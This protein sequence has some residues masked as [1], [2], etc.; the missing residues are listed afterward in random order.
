MT[1]LNQDIKL[2][3]EERLSAM[4]KLFKTDIAGKIERDLDRLN[5]Y[6]NVLERDLFS[7]M[8]SIKENLGNMCSR[9]T[10]LFISYYEE[11]RDKIL[12]LN[13][14]YVYAWMQ[15]TRMS[16]GLLFDSLDFSEKNKISTC[17]KN[18]VLSCKKFKS[19]VFDTGEDFSLLENLQY[20]PTEER[21]I[22]SEDRDVL[23]F[24]GGKD[25]IFS[26]ALP[27]FVL[28][29]LAEFLLP[30]GLNEIRYKV[31]GGSSPYSQCWKTSCSSL[32]FNKEKNIFRIFDGLLFE[33][34]KTVHIGD[35]RGRGRTIGIVSKSVA[36]SLS[37]CLGIKFEGIMKKL[38]SKFYAY[39]KQL[40]EDIE[41]ID[42]FIKGFKENC[43][44]K[45]NT[46]NILEKRYVNK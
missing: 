20:V 36:E 38:D 8:H 40:I 7:F 6:S 24:N 5:E 11:N 13:E 46:E 42:A 28:Q 30:T 9:D 3:I 29:L 2:D 15:K 22:S 45:P 37:S 33:R 34:V 39:S 17:I 41:A 44:K 31:A 4:D 43:E 23:F 35:R 12:D 26:E 27:S 10:N 14:K 19:F 32:E 16:K 18:I 1:A 21:N 25:F